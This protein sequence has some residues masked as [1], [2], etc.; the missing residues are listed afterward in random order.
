MTG[1]N[2]LSPPVENR[3]EL[4]RY[5]LST[6]IY[7]ERT[8][9]QIILLRRAE[10]S[11]MAGL[12]FPPGGIVDPGEDPWTAAVRELGEETGLVPVGELQ[13]VGCYPMFVYG[14]DFLQLSFRCQVDGNVSISAE[15]TDHRWVEP[16]SLQ[17]LLSPAAI[18]ELADGDARVEAL[19]HR[20]TEDLDRYLRLP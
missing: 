17:E 8:D 16:T 14:Q 20:I 3:I 4:D 9:G 13:M 10:G 12:F 19:L 7:A 6:V 5:A 1:E 2:R 15:H 11:A 18:D